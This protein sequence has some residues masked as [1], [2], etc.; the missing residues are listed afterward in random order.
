MHQWRVS[1]YNPRFRNRKGVYQADDWTCPSDIGKVF[2]G[3]RLELD[4][5]LAM[6]D[7][8]VSTAMHFRE[9]SGLS[10]LTVVGLETEIEVSPTVRQIGLDELLLQGSELQEEQ[11]LSG[12]EL[13]RACRLNLRNL[14]YCKV[15]ESGKFFIHFG[16][17][18]YMYLGSFLP[19]PD[20]VRYG[21]EVGLFVE[22]MRSP[23]SSDGV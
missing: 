11:Q 19:C 17:D 23:L 4:E 1:K 21:Q 9:E 16:Y 3:H 10:S 8:Y 2:N 13:A 14:L 22:P 7:R 12:A 18:Y 6:E 20:S 5:Y 15:E